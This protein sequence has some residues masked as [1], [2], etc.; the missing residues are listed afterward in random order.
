MAGG[1]Q[2]SIVFEDILFLKIFRAFRMAIQ[3][4]KLII[5]SAALSLICLSGWIMDFS[6][7][8]AVVR[9][10]NNKIILTELQVYTTHKDTRAGIERLRESG[11]RSGVFRI[12]W[13]SAASNFKNAVNF[14][15]MHNV[16]GVVSCISSFFKSLEWALKYHY[17]YCAVFFIIVLAVMSAAGGAICRIAALQNAQGEKPGMTEAIR[18]STKRFKSLFA[19]PLVPVFIILVIGMLIFITGLLGNIPL[20]GEIIIG[21]G[22]PVVLFA[23]TIIAVVLIGA[24][25]GFNLMFPA[26]AYDGSDSFDSISRSFSYV[27]ARPWRMLLYTS[28]AAIYGSICYTF[29]RVVA[30]LAL[31]VARAFLQ[32]VIWTDNSSGQVNKLDAIWPR[33]TPINFYDSAAVSAST[34]PEKISA[35]LI[36][37]FVLVI[38]GL[39]VSFII[40]FYFSA[41]TIIYSLLRNKVDNTAIDDVYTYHNEKDTEADIPEPIKDNKQSKS[42]SEP[43]D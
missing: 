25:A 27:Y 20:V 18:F 14:V 26:V 31:S 15:Y 6:K 32:I 23:G 35:A 33:P 43:E 29:V 21:L 11:Q 24:F 3:P 22:M 9:D 30:F 8:V 39:V 1:N 17:I 41:N 16:L 28:V 2:V 34:T 13:G 42:D 7:T 19:A 40:S 4:T 12:L 10:S 37:F 38:I 36:Y 5:T